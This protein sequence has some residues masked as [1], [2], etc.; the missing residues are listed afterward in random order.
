YLGHVDASQVA[1]ATHAV[2]VWGD[3]GC[4]LGDE[5]LVVDGEGNDFNIDGVEESEASLQCPGLLR[6]REQTDAFDRDA[7]DQG[8]GEVAEVRLGGR[9]RTLRHG[10]RS[11]P[12]T[13]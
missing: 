11:K 4:G 1:T 10:H 9:D 6:P 2:Q 13:A 8:A 5:C 3:T 12:A 7:L